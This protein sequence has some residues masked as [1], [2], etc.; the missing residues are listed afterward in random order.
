MAWR[1]ITAEQY[2]CN[3]DAEGF[4]EA[5]IVDPALGVSREIW[6]AGELSDGSIEIHTASAKPLIVARD[7][8]IKVR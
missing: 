3:D 5:F 1:T 2:L 8:P 7:H 4:D 6:D